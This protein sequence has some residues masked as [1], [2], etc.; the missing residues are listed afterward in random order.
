MHLI[1]S[2]TLIG[3][4]FSLFQS[5]ADFCSNRLL[6]ISVGIPIRKQKLVTRYRNDFYN[7]SLIT[8]S[9][10]FC[11]SFLFFGFGAGGWHCKEGQ[12]RDENQR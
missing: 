8:L 5:E 12:D 6:C 10:K 2:I 1:A 9:L 3:V 4:Y 7:E 11:F